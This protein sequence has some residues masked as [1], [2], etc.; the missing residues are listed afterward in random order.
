MLNFSWMPIVLHAMLLSNE[1]LGVYE[2][3]VDVSL[4]LEMV[5]RT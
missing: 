3:V 5:F 4:I 1:F 2:H